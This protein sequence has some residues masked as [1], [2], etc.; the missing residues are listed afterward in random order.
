MSQVVKYSTHT[1]SS[2]KKSI[3]SVTYIFLKYLV[4]NT[5]L[6][7]EYFLQER[8]SLLPHFGLPNISSGTHG[9]RYN[10]FS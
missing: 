4:F 10:R 2:P 7:L 1:I 8:M 5:L 6:R 9:Q 3:S